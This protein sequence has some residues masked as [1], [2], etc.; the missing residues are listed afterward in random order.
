MGTPRS[1]HPAA[2]QASDTPTPTD[3]ADRAVA[4]EAG[5]RHV[6]DR[7]AGIRR[8]RC[9]RGF[10]YVDADG[11]SVSDAATLARIRA[12][13]IPPAYQDVW[14]CASPRGHLQATG[15]DARGR[16]QYR[17][18]ADWRSFRDTGKFERLPDFA[19]AL[20]RLRRSLRSDLAQ[21]GFPRDKVLA[22][23]VRIMSETLL[24]VGNAGYARDNGSYGLTTLRSRH[25]RFPPGA[26]RLQFK[27]KGGRQLEVELDD[28]RL[29]RMVRAIHQLPGQHLFQYHGDGGPQPVDSSMV[30]AYLQASMGAPF[31]AKDFR[32]WGATLA[33]FRLLAATPPPDDA[34]EVALARL[35]QQVVEEVA[36]TLGNTPAVCRSSY[37]DPCV[38]EGWEDGSLA[39]AA[40]RARGARQW[41]T[42]ALRFLARSHRAAARPRSRGNNAAKAKKPIPP[43]RRGHR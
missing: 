1:A 39:R 28:R 4:T 3:T 24:R 32:T 21:P 9:G 20:P 13:A 38:F 26:M 18:H 10:R 14:I 41:E 17:Y 8:V 25:A 27:G 43:T 2:T 35:R 7:A 29:A 15:R 30:N 31:T 19:K 5:L 42:A 22:V 36:R 16:K 6:S 12:L 11:R 37:I 33:A 40:S 23:V 34:S